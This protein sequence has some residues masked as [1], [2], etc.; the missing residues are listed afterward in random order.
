M[1]LGFWD[2]TLVWF[3]SPLLGWFFSISFSGASSST[4]PLD[5]DVSPDLFLAFCHSF[6]LSYFS[7]FMTDDFQ[8]YV[9]TL[10]KLFP[11][12]QA[13]KSYFL[14]EL[15]SSV[16]YSDTS[17]RKHLKYSVHCHSSNSFL[18]FHGSSFSVLSL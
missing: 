13:Q 2:S 4:C 11:G 12:L 6:F 8:I 7:H 17:N 15:S 14:L 1:F 9:S 5:A 18:S 16:C 3:N 10:S